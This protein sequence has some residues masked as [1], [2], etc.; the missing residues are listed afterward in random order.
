MLLTAGVIYNLPPVRERLQPRLAALQ[1]EVYYYFNPPQEAVFIPQE[2][3]AVIVQATLTAL[4]R[5]TPQ[6][7]PTA[8]ALSSLTPT[9]AQPSPTP[10]L[11][12][13]P[14]PIPEKTLLG[15]IRHEYQQMNNC[16][17]ATLAMALSFWGWQ[18]DQRDTRAFLRPSFAEVD[19]KNVNPQEMAAYVEQAAGLKALARFGGDVDMLRRLIAAGFPV[20]IEKGFQPPHEDWMG[21][22]EALNGYDDAR[23]RFIAQDSYIMP[24]LPVP[25]DDLRGRWWRDFNYLYL[26]IYPAEREGE[27]AGVLGAQAD[28]QENLRH[29]A[30][31]AL[32]EA[33]ALQGR[34]LFFAWFN[35]GSSLASLGDYPAAA[36]A[37]D[38]A[39]AQYAALPEGERPWR[40]MWYQSGPYEAYYHTARYQD[41]ID[42]ANTTLSVFADPALEEAFYWRGLARRA[43]GD[44]EG[45]Q[46][47]LNKAVRL[48]PNF[49]AA[50]E[51][52]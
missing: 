40:M 4:P 42:L 31:L 27:V 28:P 36:E 23:A 32:E 3:A 22:Y 9:A 18:G 19:D 13:L 34:D 29:A 8:A 11:R 49:T 45:G 37:Y 26:V 15:G 48:N 20:I 21:H 47:D 5:R 41:V 39:F 38:R 7:S 43:L 51:A 1:S 33:A 14:T 44:L 16:G 52:R 12:P 35:R 24:D 6:P 17:P 30:Q 46:K 10:T 25:Y 2:Q 50:V